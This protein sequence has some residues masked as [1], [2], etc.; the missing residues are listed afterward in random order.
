MLKILNIWN[1][2]TQSSQV[3]CS[4][5][6]RRK[7][8]YSTTKSLGVGPGFVWGMETDGQK[9]LIPLS[10]EPCLFCQHP[11]HLTFRAVLLWAPGI[12]CSHPLAV[13]IKNKMKMTTSVMPMAEVY[14]A[15]CYIVFLNMKIESSIPVIPRFKPEMDKHLSGI[16]RL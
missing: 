9:L 16:I 3:V 4:V 11:G 13:F 12:T 5:F 10:L 6:P 7:A 14:P 8:V 1:P 15:M 2:F